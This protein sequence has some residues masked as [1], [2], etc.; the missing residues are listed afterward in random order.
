ML[1]ELKS[2][3]IEGDEDL[4]TELIK[5]LLDNGE[6][7]GNI[8]N[9][10]L[11]K[12]MDVVGQRFK[13]YEMYLPEVI[14]S[15]TAMKAAMDLL[16]PHISKAD[17]VTMGKIVMATIE[18]D[19]HDIGKNLVSMMLEG[20]G[21]EI[22]D[23]GVDVSVKR[24]IESFCDESADIIGISALLTTTML[25]LERAIQ[26]IRESTAGAKVIVGGA[27]LTHE[28]AEK[29]GADGFAPDALRA[30]NLSKNLSGK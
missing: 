3:I 27:P 23:L 5:T 21:F 7:P 13:T 8:L 4:A 28:Y 10:G 26:L 25:A 18:G 14:M 6:K 29:I 16:K 30:I 11:L 12:G 15:A 22:I 1:E 19:V 2:A 20:A 24:I 9:K 17:I